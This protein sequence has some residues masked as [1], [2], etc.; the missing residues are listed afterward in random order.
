MFLATLLK[1]AKNPNVQQVNGRASF[2]TLIECDIAE[3]QRGIKYRYTQHY[4]WTSQALC[5]KEL[6][7]KEYLYN[8][9]M[10]VKF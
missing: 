3:Q 5:W 7:P 4:G 1:I 6:A 9:S 2:G 8:D 10:Y